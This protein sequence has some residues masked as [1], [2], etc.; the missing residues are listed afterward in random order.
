MKKRIISAVLAI[1]TV[2]CALCGRMY[3]IIQS[4]EIVSVQSDIRVRELGAKRGTI[5][6]KNGEPLVNRTTETTVCTIPSTE[7]NITIR[8]LKGE[9]FAEQTV[10]K[11]YL[12]TFKLDEGQ[13]VTQ[14][15]NIKTFEIYKRYTDNVALHLLGYCDSE[16]NGVCGVEKYFENEIKKADGTL[17]IAYSADAFGRVLTAEPVEIRNNNYYSENGIALT[18]DRNFQIIAENALKNGNI[19]KGAAVVLDIDSGAVLACASTPSY[20]REN[21]SDYLTNDDSPFLNRALCAYPVGSVFKP[22]TAA[23]ALESGIAPGVFECTG[24]IEKSGNVFNCS[25]TEGHG[26][27]DFDTAVAFSCNP[28]FIELS[29]QIKAETLLKTATKLGFSQKTDLGNGF[30]S[31]AGTLPNKNELNSD[32]AIGNLGFGQGKLTATPMQIAACFAVF[33][34]GGTYY[35]PYIFKGTVNAGGALTPTASAKGEKILKNTTCEVISKA[36]SKTTVYGTGI[37]AYSSLFNACTKTAT[38]QSGQYDSNGNEIKYCWFAG[39]FPYESPKYAVCILKENGN[40]GGSDG[41]P[42]FKEISEKI[43]ISELNR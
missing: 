21:L 31:D 2:F 34:N 8:N 19:D 35:K 39:Y 37:G 33:A 10:M 20:E 11:G 13:T 27:I 23:A 5:Y 6:D 4:P 32:A 41:A 43:Y 28:Y 12:T 25:K 1:I 3:A 38:A 26:L 30:M 18:I 9:D 42:V 29:T 22:V 17:E 24:N 36:L 14:N 7:T 15:G 16:G 40:S